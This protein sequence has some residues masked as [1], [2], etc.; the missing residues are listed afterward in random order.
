M[1]PSPNMANTGFERGGKKEMDIRG[2]MRL[3]PF[4]LAK[5]KDKVRP[6]KRESKTMRTRT[7]GVGE[8]PGQSKDRGLPKVYMTKELQGHRGKGLSRRNDLSFPDP[9]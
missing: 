2:R 3:N 7:H 5:S 9:K 8:Y 4:L 1:G 6:N